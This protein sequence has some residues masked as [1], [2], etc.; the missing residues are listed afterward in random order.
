VRLELLRAEIAERRVE[1]LGVVL[2]D[3]VREMLG[4]IL[5]GFPIEPTSLLSRRRSR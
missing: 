1:A 3:E 5:G 2:A 4:D